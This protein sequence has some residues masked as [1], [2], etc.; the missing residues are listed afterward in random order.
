MGDNA[1]N[2]QKFLM[3]WFVDNQ[4]W[5]KADREKN[6]GVPWRKYYKGP[7]DRLYRYVHSEAL[8]YSFARL[9]YRGTCSI[10]EDISWLCNL[11][12]NVMRRTWYMDADS[13]IFIGLEILGDTWSLVM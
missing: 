11:L 8:F 1:L 9:S 13:G 12:C 10:S 6:Q 5:V 7:R 2:D 3:N 4:T